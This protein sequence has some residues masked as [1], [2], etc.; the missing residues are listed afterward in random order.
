MSYENKIQGM[1]QVNFWLRELSESE[2]NSFAQH[3]PP[4]PKTEWAVQLSESA[5]DS[6]SPS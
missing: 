6:R 4:E 2:V 5:T 3:T 1:N